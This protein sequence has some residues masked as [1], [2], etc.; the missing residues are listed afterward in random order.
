V[1]YGLGVVQTSVQCALSQRGLKEYGY[2]TSP[3]LA[4]FRKSR[5][6]DESEG[7][8]PEVDYGVAEATATARS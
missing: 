2:L 6:A 4:S 1:R 8:H 7:T 3:G 5:E